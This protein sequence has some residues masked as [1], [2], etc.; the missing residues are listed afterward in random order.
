MANPRREEQAKAAQAAALATWQKGQIANEY[1]E[2]THRRPF[3]DRDVERVLKSNATGVWRYHDYGQPRYGF[4]HPVTEIFVV[5]QPEEEGYA[6]QIKS[7]FWEDDGE[8]YMARRQ[9]AIL[10]RKPKR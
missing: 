5:W 7:A 3:S 9:D 1:Y 10:L 8:T 2:K 4:W 6:S